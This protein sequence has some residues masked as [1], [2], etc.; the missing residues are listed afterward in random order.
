MISPGIDK[1]IY[2]L[3]FN[4]VGRNLMALAIEGVVF[5]ILTLLIQYR[6]KTCYT[7]CFFLFFYLDWC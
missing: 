4:L 3:T 2:P 1:Y 5:F 7:A 6:Y